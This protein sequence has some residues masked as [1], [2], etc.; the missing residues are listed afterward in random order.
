MSMTYSYIYI[1]IFGTYI[2]RYVCVWTCG[3]YRQGAQLPEMCFAC[4]GGWMSRGV[5]DEAGERPV[6]FRWPLGIW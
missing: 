5:Q 2:I 4:L 3:Y 6:D 1:Y